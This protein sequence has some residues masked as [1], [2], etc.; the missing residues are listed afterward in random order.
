MALSR[1]E[2]L[3]IAKLSRLELAEEDIATYQE[4]LGDI[5][6]YATKLDELDTTGVPEALGGVFVTNVFREDEQV[7]PAQDTRREIINAFPHT[8]ADLLKVQAV[9]S[10]RTE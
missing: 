7:P 3:H 8:E 4:Q 2:I 5:L 6:A 1:E 10:D 9:F